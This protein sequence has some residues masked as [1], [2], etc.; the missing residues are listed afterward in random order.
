MLLKEL[1]KGDR[2][3]ISGSIKPLYEVRGIFENNIK[4]F[5]I[6]HQIHTQFRVYDFEKQVELVYRPKR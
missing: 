4:A 6:T 1:K 5:N 2:F 3:K